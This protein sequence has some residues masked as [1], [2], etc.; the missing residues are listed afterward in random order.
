[1]GTSPA[2]AASCHLPFT[3]ACAVNM[4]RVLFLTLLLALSSEVAAAR[5]PNDRKSIAEPSTKK[6][7]KEPTPND[8]ATKFNKAM[9]EN[10]PHHAIDVETVSKTM[11]GKLCAEDTILKLKNPESITV[12]AASVS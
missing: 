7:K 5:K 11:L 9:H 4:K 6:C 1:M 10:T 12:R 3:A 8:L 2:A